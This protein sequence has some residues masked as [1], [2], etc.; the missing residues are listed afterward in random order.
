MANE[1]KLFRTNLFKV[2]GTLANVNVKT[3][4]A[5]SGGYVSVD[6]VI[7]AVID[8]VNNEYQIGFYAAETTKEGKH[9]KL[10]DTYVG[11]PELLNKKVEITG[12]IRENRYWSTNL[13][14]LISTQLLSGRW[15]KGVPASTT[16]EGSY[17]IGGFIGRQVTERKNKNDEV[18]RYDVTL[19]QSN[20]NGDGMS[21]FTLHINPEN[22]EILNG[23]ESYE[24]GETVKLKGKLAFT[25]ETKTEADPNSGFGEP[26]MR[27]YTNRQRNFYIIGGSNPGAI[28]GDE[29]Y[30][31]AVVK[32]LKEAYDKRDVEL[33]S[34]A[35]TE[36][37]AAPVVNEAPVTRRQTSLL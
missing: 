28:T 8:G 12:E 36:A 7:T 26:M 16:D 2:V 15:V 18:Y 31:P 22:R 6:A 27:T 30:T 33:Q 21:I 17:E 35:K 34:S 1:N 25:V 4:V 11:L 10:Y 14:Q 5:K 3:G 20:F 23:V 24:I 19:G 29:A 32:Q 37:P 13:G 9:S